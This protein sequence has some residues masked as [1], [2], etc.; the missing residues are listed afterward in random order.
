MTRQTLLLS[1]AL[2]SGAPC[3]AEFRPQATVPPHSVP[4]GITFQGQLQQNGI[5]VTSDVPWGFVFRVW[6]AATNGNQIGPTMP[7]AS[8]ID[9]GIFNVSIPVTTNTLVGGPQRWLD[10]E[11]NQPGQT[12]GSVPPLTPRARLFSVPYALVA[13]ALE[14]TIDV[15]TNGITFTTAP[16]NGNAAFYVSTGA[17]VGIGAAHPTSL[18]HVTSGVVTSDGTG[19]NLHLSSG[20]MTIDGAGATLDI[21]GAAVF[22]SGALRPRFD[23]AGALTMIGPLQTGSGGTGANL[24][25]RARGDIPYFSGGGGPLSVLGLGTP[26]KVLRNGGASPVWTAATY[27]DTIL[28]GQLLYGSVGGNAISALG[29]GAAG[30]LLRTNGAGADPAWTQATYPNTVNQGELLYGS[31]ANAVSPLGTG[32]AG[33]LLR[34]GGAGANPSW[35]TAIYPN[36]TTQNRLLYSSANDIVSELPTQNNGVLATNGAGVPGIVTA[37]GNSM[38]LRIPNAGGAPAFGA[39][40]LN[41]ANA[42][43]AVLSP[44]NGGTGA[45]L[46]AA[47]AWGSLP[48]FSA[49]NVMATLAPAAA[50]RLLTSNGAG[51][52]PSWVDPGTGGT[53]G[54]A[55]NLTGGLQGSIPYQNG[56]GAT[57]MLAAGTAGQLLRTAG[58]GANPTWTTAVYPGTTTANWI[59]YSDLNNRV[60][61]LPTQNN[62]LLRT[63]G[64]GAPTF[65]A[66]LPNVT[67]GGGYIYRE[68]GSVVD[69]SAGGT[70]TDLSG[71]AA[72]SLIYKAAGNLAGSGAL[73]G[74]VRGDAASA[75]AP[76][77][78]TG[79]AN[80]LVYWVTASTIGAEQYAPTSAGGTGADLSAV[81]TNALI[82]KNAAATLGSA[83]IMPAGILKGGGAGVP[84]AINGTQNLIAYWPYAITIG[85]TAAISVGLGGTGADLSAV[86]TNALIFKSA[87]TTLGSAGIMPAGILK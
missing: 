54:T 86:P 70:G 35:T 78:L 31:A 58:A 21:R 9:K 46:S 47:S 8:A 84:T 14:G 57:S 75:G 87:A 65:A 24:T 38:V 40:D 72:G 64:G 45:D 44:A 53:A 30:K 55:N 25:G 18:L 20:P 73:T 22:G 11:V 69:L 68:G 37:G 23:A 49:A 2:L 82:Y 12:P 79:T 60:T 6:D 85:S 66:D 1:L 39:V 56:I 67:M 51:F 29:T 10:V 15:S 13:K 7:T 4:G 33:A 80:Q 17:F 52:N 83:G 48:Y 59:L 50:N 42:V 76:T 43:T 19:T 63:D 62:R 74:V 81:P 71:A 77:A 26:G 36:T 5:P 41:Q 61:D 3:A 34:T 27:P 16:A 28:Q 32:A